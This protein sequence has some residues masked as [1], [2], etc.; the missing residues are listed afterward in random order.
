MVF[1]SASVTCLSVFWLIIWKLKVRSTSLLCPVATSS[2]QS[3]VI[4]IVLCFWDMQM[5]YLALRDKGLRAWNFKWI[6]QE[7]IIVILFYLGF[8]SLEKV[9]LILQCASAKL[10]LVVYLGSFTFKSLN[11]ARVLLCKSDVRLV[12]T[13]PVYKKCN[14]RKEIKKAKQAIGKVYDKSTTMKVF[15]N[16]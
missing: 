10:M 5:Y 12:C 4:N 13:W 7:D 6:Y 11:T 8:S 3:N 14:P 15:Y 9:T 1:L 16:D 2:F